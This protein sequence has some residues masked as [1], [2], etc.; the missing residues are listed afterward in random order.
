VHID[1]VGAFSNADQLRDAVSKVQ[2]NASEH[3]GGLKKVIQ[4][5]PTDDT[6]PELPDVVDEILNP[7]LDQ[8]LQA[9]S[10]QAE[11]YSAEEKILEESNK[12]EE[13]P[14]ITHE[15]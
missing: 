14:E 11:N 8:D 15:R 13:L 12:V 4:P 5:L 3:K 9:I 1:D 2:D 10:S 7:E 6:Q